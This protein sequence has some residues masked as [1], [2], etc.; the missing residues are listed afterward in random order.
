MNKKDII[1]INQEI[2]EEG[3]LTNPNSLEYI[4][5][6]QEIGEE[7]ELTNPSALDYAVDRIRDKKDWLL[8]LGYLVRSLLIDHAFKEGN[9]RTA[10]ALILVYFEDKAIEYDKQKMIRIISKIAAKN[11]TNI[12]KIARLIKSAKSS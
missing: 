5:I 12:S 3:E 4:R 11:I 1:R 6:N 7:G 8:E 9:K 2:G 10:L